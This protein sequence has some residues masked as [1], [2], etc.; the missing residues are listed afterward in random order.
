MPKNST[1][2]TLLITIDGQEYEVTTRPAD[3]VAAEYAMRRD[4]VANPTENAPILMQT[5]LAHAAFGRAH[6]EHPAARDWPK[7]LESVENIAEDKDDDEPDPLD[8][9]QLMDTSTWP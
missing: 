6:P 5:R 1:I 7:F 4:K 2:T 8:P 9:T 3:L